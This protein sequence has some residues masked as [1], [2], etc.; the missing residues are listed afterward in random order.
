MRI[1]QRAIIIAIEEGAVQS[2]SVSSARPVSVDGMRCGICSTHLQEYDLR[3]VRQRK[4]E[5]VVARRLRPRQFAPAT[6]RY[7][8]ALTGHN[9]PAV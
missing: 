4:N 8:D 7:A 5:R 6:H 3:E 2:I 1:S 9:Q